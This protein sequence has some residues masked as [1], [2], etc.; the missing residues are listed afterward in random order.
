MR[1]RSIVFAEASRL[2]RMAMSAERLLRDESV[3]T[4][5]FHTL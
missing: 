3:G 1:L 4:W 2:S 5:P